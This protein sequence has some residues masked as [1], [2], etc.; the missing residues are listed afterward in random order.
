M[1]YTLRQYQN[2]IVSEARSHFN[3]D[4]QSVLIEAPTGSGKTVLLVHMFDLAVKRGYRVW[5]VV[6][7]VEL[8]R[9]SVAAFEEQGLEV[10]I[11]AA[12]FPMNPDR[13]IQV[14]SIQTLA[15]R[16][17]KLEPPTF[18]GFD[19]CHHATAATW[20]KV[21]KGFPK[22]YRVGLTATP[23]RLDGEGLRKHFDVMVS[24]PS[25]RSLIDQRYLSDFRV[26]AP[27]VIPTK[28]LHTRM[29]D[30]VKAELERVADRAFITGNVVEHYL[31]LC[32]GMRALAFCVSIRHSEHVCQ[33]FRD[34]GVA[35]EHVCSNT[36]ADVREAA[37]E[38]FK[39]GTTK[40]LTS[41]ELFGEGV[42]VPAM[43]AAILLRPTQS[44]ALYRQQVGRA[45]R[46]QEGKTAV[47]LDHAGNCLR[48]GLPD[49]EIEWSLDSKKGHRKKKE[50]DTGP[51]VRICGK[52]FAAQPSGR[53]ICIYCEYKFPIKYRRVPE[54]KGELVEVTP[55][56]R[57]AIRKSRK[58]EEWAC[59][60]EEELADL[61][62]RRG[63]PYARGWARHRWKTLRWRRRKKI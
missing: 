4:V 48:H 28:G 34:A 1:P 11:I 14:A 62:K 37:M 3:R 22:A 36:P 12:G 15:R 6:H 51:S 49:E 27:S 24:G 38:R 18:I 17:T 31:R 35:T 33:A 54:R 52:C 13:P 7:R 30:Y 9:Q 26:Y 8:L 61:G 20:T 21:I 42:D 55:E 60:S 47:I 23:E 39:A 53:P 44:L 43:E 56:Q 63:Y 41:V 57:E 2:A 32:D 58:E 45:L 50:G 29:G 5:F 10:G 46:P 59:R 16:Y 19:E 40:I 25:V